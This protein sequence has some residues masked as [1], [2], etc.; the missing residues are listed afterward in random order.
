MFVFLNEATL[1]RNV[2]RC[3]RRRVRPLAAAV[4]LRLITTTQLTT[5]TTS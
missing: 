4:H 1:R 3:Q 2:G 5:T